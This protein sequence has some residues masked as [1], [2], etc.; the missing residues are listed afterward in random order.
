MEPSTNLSEILRLVFK[1]IGIAM[2]VSVIVLNVLGV[3]TANIQILLLAIGLFG[4]A[5]GSMSEE[6][7]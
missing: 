5:L 1:A 3:A 7:K 2:A 4:L 6:S